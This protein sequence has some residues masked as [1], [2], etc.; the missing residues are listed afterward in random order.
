MSLLFRVADLQNELR[1]FK[2]LAAG[3]LASDSPSVLSIAES[4]LSSIAN[5]AQ[6]HGWEI[7]RENPLFTNPSIG[8]Y[9]P[10]DKGSEVIFGEISFIWDLQ[11]VRD[12]GRE[13]GPALKVRLNGRASTMVR[14]LRG[15]PF[16]GQ[17]PDELA[18]WRMEIA[19]D[20]AP[21]AFFHIQIMGRESDLMFPHSVDIPRFP[22]VFSSP[23]SAIEFL[24]GE[25]FQS[26]WPRLVQSGKSEAE[27][28]RSIQEFRH[29]R[30]LKWATDCIRSGGGSPWSSW[31]QAKPEETMFIR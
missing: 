16:S 9:M 27:Q 1:S 23:F 31:K 15:E 25:L 11:P 20:A 3:L 13:H 10:D 6:G 17:N 21:G 30:Y 19:D 18:M 4:A 26:R 8:E 22:C 12:R 14:L 28:W 29:E 24:L 7:P 2:K 5:S